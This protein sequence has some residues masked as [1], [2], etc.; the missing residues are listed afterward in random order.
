MDS[1]DTLH[2][3]LKKCVDLKSAK[4]VQQQRLEDLTYATSGVFSIF[5]KDAN[6]DFVRLA[7]TVRVKDGSFAVGTKLDRTGQAYAA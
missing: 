4:D 5:R 7:T 1:V 6:S 2:L 3:I